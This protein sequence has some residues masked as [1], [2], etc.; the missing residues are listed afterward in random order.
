MGPRRVWT[1]VGI[2]KP[3]EKYWGEMGASTE[4]VTCAGDSGTSV[5]AGRPQGYTLSGRAGV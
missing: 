1:L 5:Y 3:M 4:L 2:G